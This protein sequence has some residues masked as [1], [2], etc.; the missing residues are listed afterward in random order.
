MTQPATEPAILADLARVFDDFQGRE[1]SGPLGSDTRFFADLGLA[2]I[3]AVVLGEA[4]QE[5]YGRPLPFVDLM[6]DLGR[7]ED[8]DLTLGELAAFLAA[9]IHHEDL[10]RAEA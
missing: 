9:H 10:P 1:Y 8:R 2:S 5:R 7:R 4:L 3:D 6:A